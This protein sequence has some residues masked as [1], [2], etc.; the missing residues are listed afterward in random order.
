MSTLKSLAIGT[1]FKVSRDIQH[2]PIL[3]FKT[4]ILKYLCERV[5]HAL[6]DACRGYVNTLELELRVTR[7][8]WVLEIEPGYFISVL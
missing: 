1:L 8:A 2:S 4:C 7:W 5:V 3:F 6:E